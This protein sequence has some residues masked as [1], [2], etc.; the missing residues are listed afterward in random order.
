MDAIRIE[1]IEKRFGEVRAL[2]GVDL[3]VPGG[4]TFGL[5]GPNGAGKTTLMGLVCGWLRPT[6]GTISVLGHSPWRAVQLKGKISAFPQDAALPPNTSVLHSLTYFGRLQGLSASRAA[7]EAEG[8]LELAGLS[9]WGAPRPPLFPT[10]WPSAWALPRL[11]SA[12]PS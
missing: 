4:S 9:E 2:D 6:S 10:E 11:S 5:I 12:S 8:A 3:T 1:G 7:K